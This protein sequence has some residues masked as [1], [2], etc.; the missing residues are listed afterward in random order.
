M[1]RKVVF[2]WSNIS[3]YM[4]ACWQA[5]QLEPNLAFHVL[6][7]GGS[8]ET[9]FDNELMSGLSWRSLT[10]DEQDSPSKILQYV[11]AQ[12]PDVIFLSGWL[13]RGYMELVNAPALAKT[14]FVLCMDTPWKGTYRQKF[15][16]WILRWFLKR[17]DVAF[18]PG[19]RAWLYARKLGFGSDRIIKGLYGVDHANLSKVLE[20]RKV[21]DWPKRF[22]FVGRL[23]EQKGLDLLLQ[24]YDAYRKAVSEPWGL[25]VA[26]MGSLASQCIG[27]EGVKHHGFLQPAET[28]K[29]MEQSGV[30]VL[31]SRY[32]PWPL[33]LVEGAAAGLP[34]IC[35]TECG[36]AVEVIR[37][38][39]NGWVV[40]PTLDRL[41]DALVTAHHTNGLVKMGEHASLF[42]LPYSSGGWKRGV[43]GLVRRLTK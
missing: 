4:A 37:D 25:D 15:S 16:P 22:L 29:L 24:A 7:L 33:A 14:K 26:G 11:E 34:V 13:N 23:H 43:V 40:P 3:G 21:L 9:N 36:S 30:L 1:M 31:P 19:E 6:A 5:L 17:I 27:K 35:S 12:K 28:R 32:D 38:G 8:R 20:R 2:C 41:V 10:A 18:V 39:F 42:A